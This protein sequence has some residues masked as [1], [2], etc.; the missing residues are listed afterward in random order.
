MEPQG[1][2][3]HKSRELWSSSETFFR[4]LFRLQEIPVSGSRFLS[5]QL[6]LNRSL[7]C[8]PTKAPP[9]K[10]TQGR[11]SPGPKRSQKRATTARL[12]REEQERVTKRA[13]RF[14]PRPLVIFVL[15]VTAVWCAIGPG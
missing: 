15:A 12:Y 3:P 11:G 10:L 14:A 6:F 5:Q 2:S 13:T 7:G 1:S 8:M 4:A 9:A